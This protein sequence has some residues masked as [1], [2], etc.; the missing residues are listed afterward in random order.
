MGNNNQKRPRMRLI[1]GADGR[2][3]PE[4]GQDIGDLWAEQ[5][6]IRLREAIEEDKRKAE[7]KQK[8]A[9]DGWLGLKRAK[10]ALPKVATRTHEPYSESQAKEIVVSLNLPKLTKPTLPR[11]PMR[12]TKKRAIIGVGVL[13]I[14]IASFSLYPEPEGAEGNTKKT[15]GSP[16]PAVRAAINERPSYDTIL[17]RGKTIEQ[18][19]G[20]ARVSPP[21]K[22]PVFAFADKIG[23][24]TVTVSQQPL[25]KS[26]KPEV[27]KSIEDLAKQFSANEKIKAD[28]TTAYVGT[29][30]K[31]PQSVVL[32]KND[33]LILI[34]ASGAVG[35]PEWIEYIKG[36]Q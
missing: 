12:F 21:D 15:Q 31:G 8:R 26:F 17:P 4:D 25:P 32:A 24:T 19:G 9:R 18:L 36:L 1:R 2:L 14:F 22:E 13:V 35:A 30:V 16:A 28:D 29:S 33:L 27:N 5:N 7:K 20:W 6:R 23:A 10:K 34:K 11:I 3:R